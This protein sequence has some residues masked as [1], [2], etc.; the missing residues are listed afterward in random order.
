MLIDDFIN[1]KKDNVQSGGSNKQCFVFDEYVLLYGSFREEELK[2]EMTISNNLKKVGVALIPTLEYKITTPVG[3]NGYVKG[4]MLQSRANG[5]W[6]YSRN[7]KN[8]DYKKRLKQIAN[9][10]H[11]KLNKFIADWLAIIDAGL[12]VDP[13]KCENFFYSTKGISFIDLNL[14]QTSIPLKTTFFEIVSVL[15]GLGRVSTAPNADCVKIITN[16]ARSFLT[17]GLDINDIKE[18]LSSHNYLLG[19]CADKKQIDS[20]VESLVKKQKLEQSTLD[21]KTV[22]HICYQ[23]NG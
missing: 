16:V 18:V 11:D 22:K 8:E 14:R 7:M 9:M 2:K 4:Y 10:D 3:Q 17:K 20:I 19:D 5:D 15:T 1:S 21:L 13:S 23:M 12:Q 6:L